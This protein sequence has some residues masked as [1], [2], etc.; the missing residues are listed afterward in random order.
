MMDGRGEPHIMDFGLAK[1]DSGE[2]TMTVE[3]QLLGTPAYMSPEQARGEGH[4]A[5]R[6]SDVY[7]MGVI[8]FE[9]LTGQLP[10]RGEKRMLLYQVMN[11]EPPSPRKLK[12][13]VP[14]DLETICLKCMEKAPARRYATAAEVAEELQRFLSNRPILARPVGNVERT[15]RWCRRNPA[16]AGVL[17]THV[18]LFVAIL[19]FSGI[20]Y[21]VWR[22]RRAER[23]SNISAAKAKQSEKKSRDALEALQGELLDRAL[24]SAVRGDV[25]QTRKTLGK[26]H[27]AGASIEVIDSLRG[28]AYLF[29]GKPQQAIEIL[30]RATSRNP[31]NSEAWSLLRWVYYNTGDKHGLQRVN[32]QLSR[33][34]RKS[35]SVYGTVFDLLA[36]V[37]VQEEVASDVIDRIDAVIEK[38]AL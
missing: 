8:L 7:A 30:E 19:I 12:G 35:D 25:D 29:E 13:T 28:L 21:D 17:I 16:L 31:S 37:F 20:A 34:S 23:E 4:E 38:P 10:F 1:R 6:R 22:A 5:D 11:N 18:F 3:G 15:W 27:N 2:I 32:E 9:M 24:V 26:A 14:R 36:A 33:G